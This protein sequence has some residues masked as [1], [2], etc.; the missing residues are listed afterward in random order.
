MG[1]DIHLFV[2]RLLP[3]GRWV[4]A[5]PLRTPTRL[6]REYG[7]PLA[8]PELIRDEIDIPRNSRLFLFLK[9]HKMVWTAKKY[10]GDE[11][12]MP[13]RGF[14]PE[15]SV[16]VLWEFEYERTVTGEEAF[17]TPWWLCLAELEAYDWEKPLWYETSPRPKAP[18]G[19][20]LRKAFS[21]F[22]GEVMPMLRSFGDPESVR[23]IYFTTV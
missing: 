12:L 14:P 16:E 19:P 4:R 2:E 11:P 10:R 3:T 7:K 22:Y 23:L 9:G 6:E 21:H 17:V 13:H 15:M 5:E 20:P 18:P 1:M 8:A